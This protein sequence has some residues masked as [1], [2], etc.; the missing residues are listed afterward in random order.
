MK[1]IVAFLLALSLLL[2]LAACAPENAP[3]PQ[4]PG[5]PDVVDPVTPDPVDPAPADPVDPAPADPEEDSNQNSA[6]LS[7]GVPDSVE[8]GTLIDYDIFWKNLPADADTNVTLTITSS[9]ESV[10]ATGGWQMIGQFEKD[11]S[12]TVVFHSQAMA[13]QAGKATLTVRI[14]ELDISAS[15]TVEIR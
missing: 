7:L 14:N 4:D 12:I 15:Q 8:E 5:T 13:Y 10:L 1:K 9:D 3:A 11:G 2:C 6:A